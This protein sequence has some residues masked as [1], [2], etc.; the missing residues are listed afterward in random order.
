MSNVVVPGGDQERL[1]AAVRT[2]GA[3]GSVHVP[4][5]SS[6]ERGKIVENMTLAGL[7][8]IKTLPDGTLSGG[9]PSYAVGTKVSLTDRSSW[10]ATVAVLRDDDDDLDAL[11]DED[12]LLA[13]DGLDSADLPGKGNGCDSS[14]AQGKRK[15]CKDC[16]CG[17]AEELSGEAKKVDGSG[18]LDTKNAEKSSC[19]NCSLGDAFRCASCPYL[20][21]P[22]F[23]PGERITVSDSL[24]TSDI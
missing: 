10:E 21:L 5:T 3:G 4:G 9:V 20:G 15:A 22:P 24:M 17:L 16:T 7:I 12:E 23:K 11:V 8:D 19:G 2:A 1:F 13:R 6:T 18:L 14:V